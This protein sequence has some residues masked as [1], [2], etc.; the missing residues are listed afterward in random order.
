MEP[1]LECQIQ[2]AKEKQWGLRQTAQGNGQV[3]PLRQC[4]GQ[5]IGFFVFWC[6][7]GCLITTGSIA[8]TEPGFQGLEYRSCAGR[9]ASKSREGRFAFETTP[10][11]QHQEMPAESGTQG[12]SA[13]QA[14]TTNADLSGRGQSTHRQGETEAQ[15][16]C[17][18]L[19]GRVGRG[20]GCFTSSQ[21]RQGCS[22]IRD[23]RDREHAFHRHRGC[24]GEQRPEDSTSG[25]G[26]RAQ[27]AAT[28]DVPHEATNGR[29]DAPLC[30]THPWY[31]GYCSCSGW[32]SCE[33][34]RWNSDYRRGCRE[35]LDASSQ[36]SPGPLSGR[37][38]QATIALWPGEGS[39]LY[40]WLIL[41]I[42][43][44]D[45]PGDASTWFWGI[46][47]SNLVPFDSF[48]GLQIGGRIPPS[49]SFSPNFDV[50][51]R[52]C[53]CAHTS[54][55]GNP[56]WRI[57]DYEVTS[58]VF[59]V[60][61][62]FCENCPSMGSLCFTL[63]A[64]AL[65]FSCLLDLGRVAI[66]CAL[67]VV[68]AVGL[69]HARLL[70]V[71]CTR[72]HCGIRLLLLLSLIGPGQ[73]S[74]DEGVLRALRQRTAAGVQQPLRA[75]LQRWQWVYR[76][77]GLPQPPQNGY[78]DGEVHRVDQA[79]PR[80][81]YSITFRVEAN[82]DAVETLQRVANG[83]TD[84]HDVLRG[85]P[86]WHLHEC[87]AS[88]RQSVVLNEGARH[89][90]L[91]TY[92]EDS[93]HPLEAAVLLEI[94]WHGHGYEDSAVSTPWMPTMTT[95]VQI[96]SHAGL[97]ISCT[98]SHRCD[99]SMN[100]A[101]LTRATAV[102]DYGDFIQIEAYPVSSPDSDDDGDSPAA[103]PR[104]RSPSCSTTTSS[105]SEEV[106][107]STSASSGI[108]GVDEYS[109]VL[110]L[111]RPLLAE[112]RPH[113][114][115]AIVPPGSR[116]WR[117]S[118]FIAWPRLRYTPWQHAD[119]HQS[120]YRDYPQ[121]DDVYFK[122][123]IAADDLPDPTLRVVLAVVSWND[124]TFFQAI[125]IPQ[126]ATTGHVLAAFGLL[127]WCG[128][129]QEHCMLYH[130]SLVWS[131]ALRQFTSHGDYTRVTI[132]QVPTPGLQDHLSNVFLQGE[133]L[134]RWQHLDAI[135]AA[136]LSGDRAQSSTLLP[137]PF[138]IPRGFAHSDWYWISISWL[139]SVAAFR[140]LCVLYRP[141]PHKPPP[142]VKVGSRRYGA[143]RLRKHSLSL[144]S[145]CVIGLILSQHFHCCEALQVFRA[146]QEETVWSDAGYIHPHG[147]P[148]MLAPANGMFTWLSWRQLSPPGNPQHD[149]CDQLLRPHLTDQGR[150]M[151]SHL[152]LQCGIYLPLTSSHSAGVSDH[153]TVDTADKIIPYQVSRPI[154]TPSRSFRGD[155]PGFGCSHDA[156]FSIGPDRTNVAIQDGIGDTVDPS[157][158][159]QVTPLY[160][161]DLLFVN[162][163][164]DSTPI[165]LDSLI[166]FSNETGPSDQST[167]RSH[168]ISGDK[169]IKSMELPFH[170]DD[171]DDLLESWEIEP[172]PN[173]SFEGELSS[174]IRQ[175]LEFSFTAASDDKTLYIYTDGSFA[176]TG[177]KAGTTWASV[178][179]AINE[180]STSCA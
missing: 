61:R 80:V 148:L 13:G 82:R 121:Q 27:P 124:Y 15:D 6:L 165:Q 36:I 86:A 56:R 174:S 156:H 34:C 28:A 154:P 101:A 22:H 60:L 33:Y 3:S 52:I 164:I 74:E 137:G 65:S 89:F 48:D 70:S 175:V 169:D 50:N 46:P 1:E 16:R 17:R 78:Y 45:A 20:Q 92:A 159:A 158:D 11:Q 141:E 135:G 155:P 8:A 149:L 98:T 57:W 112:L 44:R 136:R 19:A 162:S 122:V 67:G 51:G 93:S 55:Y 168:H 102:L 129:L 53:G 153:A 177:D 179:F 91:T 75:D 83:W 21:G 25:Y 99:T 95:P 14:G 103:L 39:W 145:V 69:G 63:Q 147:A 123:I 142:A 12:T 134:H 113:R 58:G 163:Q 120:F 104:L 150:K 31:R 71:Q 126:W 138:P 49:K 68:F 30:C 77:Y 79:P 107:S 157:G 90:I 96:L 140:L 73:A 23:G 110:H 4:R 43:F 72:W 178:V 105:S 171:L 29:N 173:L 2:K 32:I 38:N 62:G 76:Y 119:V 94:I 41:F 97:L 132:R 106:V 114:V 26:D 40:G 166:T 88:C 111:F 5:Y 37:T 144:F 161:N 10:S 24:Q 59:A 115:H 128:A 35:C 180:W 118:V 66:L 151:C 176:A 85:G 9:H 64:F 125:R 7:A 143:P 100:G 131:P 139:M 172:M 160:L 127:S 133:D 18:D 170:A 146:I 108:A 117:T 130:N 47:W 167:S 54:K 152:D 42:E 84:V 81:P 109:Q 116:T 87:H